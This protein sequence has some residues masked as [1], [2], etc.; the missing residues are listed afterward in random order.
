M[1]VSRRHFLQFSGATLAALG[2]NQLDIQRQ[3][4]RYAQVLAQGT[5]RKLALLVGINTYPESSNLAALQ[6]CVTDVELQR[7]LLIHRFGF[8]AADILTLTDAKATRQNILAAFEQ[9]LIRQAKPG[10][11]VV[12]HYSGHGSQVADPDRDTPDGLNG[13]LVPVDS[14]LPAEFPAKGGTVKDIMGH[15]LFLLMRAVPTENLTVVLDSCYSGSTKRGNLRVRSRSGG[16]MIQADPAE[17]DYQRQWLSQLKLSPQDY[18]QQRRAGVAKGIVITATK[19]DQ[20]AA[21]ATFSDFSAGAFTYMMTQYLWQQTGSTIVSSAIPNISRSTTKVSSSAQEPEYEAKPGTNNPQ[22]PLYFTTQSTVPADAVITEVKGDRVRVW[23]GGLEPHSLVAFGQGA[24]LNAVDN[25]GNQQGQVKL[26]S[27]NGLTAEGRLVNAAKPAEL[28]L[29][30]QVRGIPTNLTLRVGLDS[31]LGNDRAAAKQALQAIKRVE[32]VALGQ[33]ESHY[34]LGRVTQEYAAQFQSQ[35]VKPQ[36]AI[37]EVGSIGLFYPGLDPLP[38]SFGAAGESVPNAVMRLQSK[39]RALL[40][41][42]LIKLTLNA[43]SSRLKVEATMGTKTDSSTAQ[44][45]QMRGCGRQGHCAPSEVS[46]TR[47]TNASRLPVGTP[48]YFTIKNQEAQDLYI[49]VLVI[50]PA[51]EMAV[52][53]PNQWTA[54]DDVM[55]LGGGQTLE[56]PNQSDSFK[57]QAT[58]PKG[59]TEVLIIASVSPLGTALKA[60]QSAASRGS[61]QRGPVVADEPIDMVNSLLSDLDSTRRGAE[62]IAAPSIRQISSAKLAAMS[63]TFDVV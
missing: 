52:I 40:A 23:L 51:G 2:L 27:R 39:L 7:Q 28:L 32:A 35:P 45:I 9:H 43:Q 8:Q 13:T 10:D 50:D 41:A 62:A 12:F 11:V 22:Q 49:S 56:I 54:N 44:V 20:L 1:L 4:A 21:D 37:A 3:G 15:T 5:P 14:I 48:V 26:E 29:Q 63:L 55:K 19:R 46:S 31:S 6:G 18:V 24:V 17:F 30:E 25:R 38:G 59:T 60:L 57:L 34:L 36:A 33:G 47:G 53:F 16:D 58:E 42:R 61:V